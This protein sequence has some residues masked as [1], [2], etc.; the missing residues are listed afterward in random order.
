[1]DSIQGLAYCK[2]DKKCPT[3]TFFEIIAI[4]PLT[5]LT[6]T[7]LTIGR[8]GIMLRYDDLDPVADHYAEVVDRRLLARR[9]PE[10]KKMTQSPNELVL[11]LACSDS[12]NTKKIS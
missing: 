3:R 8:Y 1:M 12:E 7:M 4:R 10:L 5:A 11:Y 9:I 2:L 6:T